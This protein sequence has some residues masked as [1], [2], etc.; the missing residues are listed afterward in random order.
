VQYLRVG[1]N[2]KLTA[3]D[4]PRPFRAV[5]VVEDSVTPEWRMAAS[6][7][8]VASGCLYM[9]AWGVDCSSWD[10]SVELANREIFDFGDIPDE[11]F[12]MTTWHEDES[13]AD[14]FEFA[15]Q[16]ALPASGNVEIEETLV[17][18]VSPIDRRR[19]Y[20]ELFASA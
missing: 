20:E 7:W 8:L 5:V 18:H 19:E 12:V 11:A 16:L 17:L 6:R 2:E 9:L 15:K 4:G 10:D 1:P 14:V 3:Y 13:L